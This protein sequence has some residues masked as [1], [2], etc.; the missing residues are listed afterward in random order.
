MPLALPLHASPHESIGPGLPDQPGFGRVLILKADRFYGEAL[1]QAVHQ[2]FP[3]AAVQVISRLRDAKVFLAA[4]RVDLLILGMNLLDGDALE[5][6]T[7]VA[8]RGHRSR[9]VLVVTGCK[10]EP[11]LRQLRSLPIDGVFDPTSEGVDQFDQA[12]QALALGRSSWSYSVLECLR[13]RR[14]GPAGGRNSNLP[15][16][17]GAQQTRPACP[18]KLAERSRENAFQL[19]HT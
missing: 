1:R 16:K 4:T 3:A 7:S 6:L 17:R 19:E 5:L 18:A 10:E 2:A 14:A 15:A 9:Q 11:V 13:E 8:L 12:L